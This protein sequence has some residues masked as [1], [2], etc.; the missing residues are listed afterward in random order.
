[1]WHY[2][3]IHVLFRLTRGITCKHNLTSQGTDPDIRKGVQKN[4]ETRGDLYPGFLWATPLSC[5]AQ[6]LQTSVMTVIC[7]L[8]FV[9]LCNAC[10]QLKTFQGS[11]IKQG[12]Q[13]RPRIDWFVVQTRSRKGD[14][15]FR[16]EY[17]YARKERQREKVRKK[18]NTRKGANWL[19]SGLIEWSFKGRVTR[20]P[21]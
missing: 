4:A 19:V 15:C 20:F 2:C 17:R 11:T 18:R 9:W 21:F 16:T 6:P 12:C 3:K 1:M 8:K 5:I 14:F 10:R 13:Q 7:K